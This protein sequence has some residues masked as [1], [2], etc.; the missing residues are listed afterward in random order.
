MDTPPTGDNPLIG[1]LSGS[2]HGT[3]RR[4]PDFV[5]SS[6]VSPVRARSRATR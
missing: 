3:E 6:K 4:T 5:V 2:L 1:K